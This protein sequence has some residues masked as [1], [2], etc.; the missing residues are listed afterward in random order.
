MM[1]SY[2]DWLNQHGRVFQSLIKNGVM[3]IMPGHISFP[4]YQ[5]EMVNGEYL[6]ATLSRDLDFILQNSDYTIETVVPV[7]AVRTV[8]L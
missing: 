5:K 3:S 2:D 7:V 1:L 6:P 8:L 4:D